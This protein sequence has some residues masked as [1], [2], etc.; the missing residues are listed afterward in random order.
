MEV[1]DVRNPTPTLEPGQLFTIE[2][3]M[4]IEDEHLG[5]RLEDLILIT[6][7]GY[8]NLSSFLPVE[9]DDIEKLMA[10][11]HSALP[12]A[13]PQAAPQAKLD[14]PN[15]P[16]PIASVH[17]EDNFWRPRIERNQAVTIPHIMRQN[18]LTGRVE[19]FVNAAKHSGEYKGRRFN[20]TDVYKVIEAA[21]YSLLTHPDAVLEK[22][23]D[24][25][26]PRI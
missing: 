2:P 23:V 13:I 14:Y 16:V 10:K 22:Q 20:D 6:E 19:N 4:Q 21:S 26:I 5:I 1:H 18:E 24:A 9:M 17:I 15:R 8:E 12:S 7:N 3:A 11:K 25:L